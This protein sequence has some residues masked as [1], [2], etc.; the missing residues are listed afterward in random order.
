LPELPEI[1]VIAEQM[2][3]EIEGRKIAEIEVRQPKILN[4]P[5]SEFVEVA[6]GKT[7][8]SVS[9][10]GKWLFVKLDPSFYVLI[11]LGM[12][13]D[14]IYFDQ[15]R[16]MAEKY[17][18][19]LMFSDYTGFTIRFSWFGYVHLLPEKEV[20][21]HKM[22]VRLGSS[23]LDDDFTVQFFR[24]LLSGRRGR[25]KSFLLDQKNI[26]GIGNVYIQDILF[27][28]RLHPNR[29]IPTLS[30]KEIV[31]LYHAIQSVLKRSIQLGGLAYEKDFYGQN[32][33]FNRDEFLVGYKTGQPC[34]ECS[35]GIMKIK[36]G[37]TSSYICPKCQSLE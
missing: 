22:T 26:A 14:L 30:D 3:N 35:T 15:E 29:K 32:G 17:Q 33:R 27:K 13:G 5:I 10:R 31:N 21:Y 19:K 8:N 4:M 2:N 28:A 1:I 37:S 25:I 34:P 23:P 11:N 6:K 7:V 24:E 20:P 9:A 12:G 36:T 18:L 16:S